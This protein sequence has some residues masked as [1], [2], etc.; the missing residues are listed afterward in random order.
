MVTYTFTNGTVADATEVNQ[1]FKDVDT[2]L[3][4]DG[5]GA[6][7]SGTTTETDIST[8]TILQNDL[9]SNATL[10]ISGVVSYDISTTVNETVNVKLYINGV[11]KK[12]QSFRSQNS[13][14]EYKDPFYMPINWI[15]TGVDTTASNIIVKITATKSSTSGNTVT[16]HTLKVAGYNK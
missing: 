1:N 5:V 11:L 9:D 3:Y 10:D 2:L 12:T 7:V 15:E 14:T 16:G 8:I 6:S 4:F 13:Q